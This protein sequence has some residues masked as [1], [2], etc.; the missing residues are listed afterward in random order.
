MLALAVLAGYPLLLLV[1]GID[2]TDMGFNLSNQWLL[3][4]D[5]DSYRHGHLFYLSNLLGGLWLAISEP[6]GLLGARLG[7]ALVLYAT[8][9][10]AYRTL[11]PFGSR[12]AILGGL[13]VALLWNSR[14]GTTWISYN[15]LTALFF[16]F[17]ALNLVRGVSGDRPR[18]VL[19]AGALLGI[20]PFIRLP[21]VLAFAMV[22]VI[23]LY[24]HLAGRDRSWTTRHVG[25]FVLGYAAGAAAVLLLMLI[26][27]HLPL[28][29]ESLVTRFSASTGDESYAYSG[30]KLIGKLLLDYENVFLALVT[31]LPVLL[32]GAWSLSGRWHWQIVGLTVIAIIWWV[33]AGQLFFPLM[34]FLVALLVV[35]AVLGGIFL[36][37]RIGDGGRFQAVPFVLGTFA[38]IML[39]FYFTRAK[40]SWFVPGILYVALAYRYWRARDADDRLIT[41]VAAMLLAITPLGSG[42]GIINA[43]FGMWLAIPL[44]LMTLVDAVRAAAER[45]WYRRGALVVTI[46][47]C[48]SLVLVALTN[49]GDSA[50]RDS[51]DRGRMTVS[52]DH[53]LLR[54]ILTTPER[55]QVVDELMSALPG[56]VSAGDPLLLHGDCP[57]LHF[58]SRTRPVLGSS[59]NGVYNERMF[60]ER[61]RVFEESD[62]SLPVVLISKGSCRDREWPD[63]KRIT[64]DGYK[65][66]ITLHGFMSRHAYRKRWENG[67]FEIWSLTPARSRG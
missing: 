1:Q 62:P 57:L 33:L 3:L 66:G 29:W 51:K 48:T 12:A 34:P 19:V 52:I 31:S 59:W 60:N 49:A 14:I 27:G 6:L 23:P 28:Y 13:V 15:S 32:L 55:A 46:V 43:I 50:Y 56:F 47:M 58:V 22:A 44:A 67:F 18:A 64:L 11:E 7:W 38:L 2:F 25:R 17:A 39:G 37:G 35:V 8:M 54:G 30:G 36:S 65:T 26:L 10:A 4:E 24:A 63:K 20:A 9:Y 42:N 16:T 21:S 53:P 40:W 45:P 5:A 41:V 61:L